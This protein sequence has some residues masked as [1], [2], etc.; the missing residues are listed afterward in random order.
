MIIATAGHVDHGKST[1]LQALTGSGDTDRLPEEKRRGMTIDLGYAYLPLADSQVLGFIDVPGH[2]KFLAN[3]LAGVDG[4]QHALLVVACDDGIMAQTREH[5][6]ILRLVGVP[7]ITVALTKADRVSV[8]RVDQVRRQVS[9]ELNA[10]GWHD[11]PMFVTAAPAGTGVAE[12]RQ[13]LVALHQASLDNIQATEHRFRLAVDRVFTVKGSGLVVTGTAFSGKVRIG[14]TLWLS[15]AHRPVRVRGIHAQNQPSEQGGAGDRIA[16]NI[17]GDISKQEVSR[18]DWLLE[19]QPPESR[20][21]VLALLHC[22]KPLRH[23]QSVH[24]HHSVN[25]TTGRVSL[26]Q[27][28]AMSVGREVLVELVFDEPL[29]LVENDRIIVRDIS[30]R[31]TLGGARVLSLLPPRRGKRQPEYLERLHQLSLA[32]NDAQILGLR[33]VEGSLSL[34]EFGWARQLTD[35]GLQNLLANAQAKVVGDTAL[36]P[37]KEDAFRHCLTETLRIFHE[38]HLDQLGLGR[39]RLRR[40]ALPSEPEGLVFALIDNLLSDGVV[41]NSRGWLHLPEFSLAFTGEELAVWERLATQFGDEPYW[42]RDLATEL[43]LDEQQVRAVLRKGAQLGHVTAVVKDRYYLSGRIRQFAD[44]I[45]TM[46]TTQG[47]TCAADFRDRL[48]VG[49]KLA[50][51]VLEFFDRSG[52]TRRQ[53]NDHLLRDSGLFL[54]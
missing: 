54:D 33:L 2:E 51:Q 40:M 5:L 45:R 8:D 17:A 16:L 50:I 43:G 9:D 48:G 52:F 29:L 26:L 24:L 6:A 34:A 19:Q 49:R 23:W 27:D 36:D 20:D 31:E 39:A 15:G 32:T 30:A 11:C 53:G 25:H 22:D 3:M 1:L 13:R 44:L 4:V 12:L 37:S 47:S 38:Q 21:R 46:H 10:Q 28:E 14:D 18:G 41:S 7:A 35:A 42:V